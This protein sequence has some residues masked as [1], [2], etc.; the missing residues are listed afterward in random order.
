MKDNSFWKTIAIIST[1]LLIIVLFTSAYY[2]SS[3]SL[4]DVCEEL[5]NISD[6]LSSIKSELD[7]ISY[8]LSKIWVEM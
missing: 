5:S 8:Y 4:G 7:D 2:E 1:S 3:A 6:E